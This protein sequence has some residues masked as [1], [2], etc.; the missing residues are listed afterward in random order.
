MPF[1]N[2]LIFIKTEEMMPKVPRT[3]FIFKNA[4]QILPEI[5][6]RAIFT[7]LIN[8]LCLNGYRSFEIFFSLDIYEQ[9]TR[10][11][12]VSS[13]SSFRSNFKW[14][15]VHLMKKYTQCY[16]S[17]KETHLIAAFVILPNGVKR[18]T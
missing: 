15:R 3:L 12:T 8:S 1:K 18:S 4:N 13:V 14:F 6:I 10:E 11:I 5:G 9:D 2:N 16:E 17:T 7:W